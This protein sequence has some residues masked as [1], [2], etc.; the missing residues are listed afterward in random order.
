MAYRMLFCIVSSPA[1]LCR[2]AI[3]GGAVF[4]STSVC[5]LDLTGTVGSQ[6]YRCHDLTNVLTYF[7]Q[8]Y[9]TKLQFKI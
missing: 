4:S 7:F 8:Q 5:W 2:R 9:F 6:S 3:T 1:H